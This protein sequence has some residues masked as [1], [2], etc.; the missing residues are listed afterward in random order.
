VKSKDPLTIAKIW[1]EWL[2]ECHHIL[3]QKQDDP[4]IGDYDWAVLEPVFL[5]AARIRG[6]YGQH[7]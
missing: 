3:D 5:H 2:D 1:W 6:V 4:Q 7:R